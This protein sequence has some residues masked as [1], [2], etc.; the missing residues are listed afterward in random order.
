MIVVAREDI[1]VHLHAAHTKAEHFWV[2][3]CVGEGFYVNEKIPM[4]PAGIEPVTFRLVA[5]HLNHCAT[6]APIHPLYVQQ[7]N[8]MLCFADRASWYLTPGK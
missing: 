3:V 6:A 4:T 2:F 7:I 8:T 5:Q 1:E